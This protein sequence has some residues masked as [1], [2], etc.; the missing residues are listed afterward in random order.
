MQW[1][2][3]LLQSTSAEIGLLSRQLEKWGVEG[4]CI[5][6]EGDFHEFLEHNRECWDYVDEGL[7]QYYQGSSQI[8]FYLPD[9][10]AGNQKLQQIQTALARPLTFRSLSN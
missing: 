3:V 4:I 5:E 1:L 2:E 7:T 9:D 10:A 6:G 8:R